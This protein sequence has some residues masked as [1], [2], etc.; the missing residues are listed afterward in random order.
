MENVFMTTTERKRMSTKTTFKRI[1]LVAVAALGLGTFVATPSNAYYGVK[2]T[3]TLT[4]SST[5]VSATVGETASVTATIQMVAGGT[6]DSIAVFTTLASPAGS[7][8]GLAELRATTDSANVTQ[9][10]HLDFIKSQIVGYSDSVTISPTGL[11]VTAKATYQVNLVNIDKAGTYTLNVI[12][13]DKTKTEVFSSQAVT[14]TVAAENVVPSATYSWAQ[15]VGGTTS[16]RPDGTADSAVVAA[17]GTVGATGSVVASIWVYQYNSDSA[18]TTARGTR[19]G[20]SVTATLVSGPGQLSLNGSTSGA[21]TVTAG[22]GDTITVLSD[23]RSGTASIRLGTTTLGTGWITKTVKFFGEMTQFTATL[24]NS[25]ANNTVALS[26]GT[27]TL[28]VYP[29]DV[30]GNLVTSDAKHGIYLTASDTK[31]IN[32]SNTKCTFTV[33]GGYVSCTLTLADSGTTTITVRDSA[34][35]ASSAFSVTTAAL[36]VAGAAYK[37]SITTDKSTYA[38][39]EAMKFTVTSKDVYDRAVADGA[40]AAFGT[41]YFTG[42]N[43]TFGNDGSASAAGGHFTD[44]LSYL[45]TPS[46]SFVSGSDTMMAFAPT[47]G[48]T[49]TLKG[50]VNGLPDQVLLT[51]TVADPTKDAADAATDAA[52]EA[53]DA[54]YA[55]Q[56]AAQLAAESAD[57]AT[58]AAE[59]ATAAAEAATAAVEDL[60]TKVAGLFADLQKQITTLANVVAKIAKKVKA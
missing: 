55:A 31:V 47:T 60:A 49:Y 19:V 52:L 16:V 7:S 38:P 57:A 23:G 29:K 54:A 15:I 14:I 40:V 17:P 39:G 12:V 44:L 30:D 34:T 9:N 25:T 53:T 26:A 4:L 36:T 41:T 46:T 56:D 18:V 27:A 50:T 1:A 3:T 33:A 13:S 48:G 5:A 8:Q 58:A 22:P 2:P 20:E 21:L 43:P 45:N 24:P 59:A 28:K 6:T 11:G 10:N 35:V 51:F 37:G 32:L 42:P